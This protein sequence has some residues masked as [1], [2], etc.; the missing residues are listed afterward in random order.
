MKGN[1]LTESVAVQV[2]QSMQAS[3]SHQLKKFTPDEIFQKID[4]L[5]SGFEPAPSVLEQLLSAGKRDYARAI[6]EAKISAIKARKDL[7][8]ELG[9]CVR[10]YA[11]AHAG[12]LKVRGSGFVT[13][14]FARMM[15]HLES[16]NDEVISGFYD[17]YKKFVADIITKDL[18]PEI[19]KEAISDAVDRLRT[20]SKRSKESMG[21]ILDNLR[22]EIERFNQ[23]I[24][25]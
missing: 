23:E 25:R 15:L 6:E 1:N 19:E 24:G 20:R 14:T 17:L 22:N 11:T 2:K 3:S 21:I 9:R 13:E 18:P 16:V 8:N 10:L 7:I 12:D 5:R 4:Q